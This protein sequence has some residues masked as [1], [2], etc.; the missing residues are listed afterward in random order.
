MVLMLRT[1]Q[2]RFLAGPRGEIFWCV[3]SRNS[4][5]EQQSE[6]EAKLKSRLDELFHWGPGA[7][8]VFGGEAAQVPGGDRG[9][10]GVAGLDADPVRGGI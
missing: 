3:E 5:K 6:R 2:L 1:G 8:A 10:Q 4:G 9:V 7:P